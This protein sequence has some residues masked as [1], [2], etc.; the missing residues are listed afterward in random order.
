MAIIGACMI[1]GLSSIYYKALSHIP[2][3]EVLAHRTLWSLAFFGAILAATGRFGELRRLVIGPQT[4]K[5]ALAALMISINWFLF[6]FSVQTGRA[7]G[8][9]LGYY[10]FPLVAVMLGVVFYGERLGPYRVMG[11][12]LA[13]IAVTVLTVGLGTLPWISLALAGTFGL[14]GVVKKG[15]PGSALTS[16]T[17]EVTLLAPLAVLWLVGLY[18]FDW[19]G[20]T[21]RVVGAFGTNLHDTVML[22]FAG[23]ITGMP[24][25]L[26]SYGAQ[27]LNY[28]MVGVLNYLNPTLQFLVATF[29][30]LEPVT[31]WHMI[32]LP[33]VWAALA[34]YSLS[35]FR[36]DRAPSSRVASAATSGT[37]DT[38]S[39]SEASA[40]P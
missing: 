28:G 3:E 11:V 5:V 26:F 12:V 8:A 40:K 24:L 31:R 34:L 25:I 35:L 19:G 38:K 20:V 18:A 37:T 21:G 13:A 29:V 30:F 14:Y 17:A 39:S 9:S 32:A 23:V 22:A 7:L 2:P 15:L 33:I 36:Q 6:I 4:G 16:V 27:R 1:W 10:I